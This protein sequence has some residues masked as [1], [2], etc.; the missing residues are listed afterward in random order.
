MITT[1]GAI[2][3]AKAFKSAV[4]GNVVSPREIARREAICSKCDFREEK[5]S[6]IS[7]LSKT[8]GKF[9]NRHRVPDSV[10]KYR[11]GVCECS[12][13]LLLPATD[14]DMHQDSPEEAEKRPDGCWLT[15]P[16]KSG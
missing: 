6:I 12:L 16:K 4:K 1:K 14:A 2:A 11:C 10:S 3:A 8:L 13:M 15:S 5:T 7:Q 9:A